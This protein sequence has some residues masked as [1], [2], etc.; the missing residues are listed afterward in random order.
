MKSLNLFDN[1]KIVNTITV[2]IHEK[3]CTI[4]QYTYVIVQ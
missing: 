2:S 4:I 3:Y 1:L